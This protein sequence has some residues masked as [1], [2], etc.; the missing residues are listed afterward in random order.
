MR[1]DLQFS[2]GRGQV[3]H[4]AYG[5][6]RLENGNYSAYRGYLEGSFAV[7]PDY[8]VVYKSKKGLTKSRTWYELV[9]LQPQ[10]TQEKMTALFASLM[11]QIAYAMDQF[12]PPANSARYDWPNKQ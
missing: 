7:A 4:V 3:R 2:D 8:L 10:L 12:V 6:S 5:L 11:P 9:P 1:F